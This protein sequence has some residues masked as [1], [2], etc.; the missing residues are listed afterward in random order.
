LGFRFEQGRG[1]LGMNARYGLDS[2]SEDG[3]VPHALFE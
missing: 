3:C 1:G 2:A